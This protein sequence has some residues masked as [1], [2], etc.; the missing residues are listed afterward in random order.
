M[1]DADRTAGGSRRVAHGAV[2]DSARASHTFDEQASLRHRLIRAIGEAACSPLFD[3]PL[4]SLG[5][6]SGTVLTT[7][8]GAASAAGV[9]RTLLG[10]AVAEHGEFLFRGRSGVA[11]PE[12]WLAQVCCSRLCAVVLFRRRPGFA[13]GVC[14]RC[15]T[16]RVRGLEAPFRVPCNL[17]GDF[18]FVLT[19]PGA[20]AEAGVQVEDHDLVAGGLGFGS[21]ATDFFEARG[22]GGVAC[23]GSHAC[24]LCGGLVGFGTRVV[25][26]G[27]RSLGSA[28]RTG[29][30]FG[31]AAWAA[32][33]FMI[34]SYS[35]GVNRPRA[36]WRRRRW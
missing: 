22:S 31:Y 25:E 14:S 12:V 5:F 32:A 6:G 33:G 30:S 27:E 19:H 18:G 21:P 28:A 9:V 35:T 20:D 23:D 16:L 3:E 13:G 34:N 17:V 29:D 26:C 7:P 2:L 4:R 1:A 8:V 15:W 36:A 24:D 10:D 11:A